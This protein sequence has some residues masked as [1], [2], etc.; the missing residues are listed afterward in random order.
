MKDYKL[1]FGESDIGGRVAQ[2][3]HFHWMERDI[4]KMS[5]ALNEIDSSI[6]EK[7]PDIELVLTGGGFIEIL[8]KD[9]RPNRYWRTDTALK[10]LIEE[11]ESET[12]ILSEMF[13]NN[14]SR[15]YI[16]GVNARFE[17]RIVGQF[18]LVFAKG[19]PKQ[20]IWKSLPLANE[21]RWLAGFGTE[22]ARE[23][24][25]IVDTSLG[26]ALVLVDND[27]KAFN[28]STRKIVRTSEFITERGKV[29]KS[30]DSQMKK[31]PPW[32]FN[33]V[34]YIETGNIFF[35]LQQTFEDIHFGHNWNPYVIGAF[36]FYEVTHSP[37][38]AFPDLEIPTQPVGLKL[39][40]T[41]S[42]YSRGR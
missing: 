5:A 7:Y 25:R 6:S 31:K 21:D 28:R 11:M 20:V 14:S 19:K 40:V 39:Y 38:I 34:N 15:D 33:L 42:E 8:I 3:K 18:A 24:P 17:D 4:S 26:K 10:R 37:W 27:V 13:L 30:M 2:I 35:I 29:I 41:P 1:L 32:V 12:A 23:C 9:K 22:Y 36:G 16:V